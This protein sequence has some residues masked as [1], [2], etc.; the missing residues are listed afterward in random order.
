MVKFGPSGNDRLFYEDGNTKTEQA[1]SWLKALGLSAYEYSFGRGNFLSIETATRIGEEAK[2]NGIEVS[3]HAPYFINFANPLDEFA[4][5]GRNYL[6]NSLRNAKLMNGKRV[7][8]H[9]GSVLKQERSVALDLAKR[10]MSEFMQEFYDQGFD[11]YFICPETMGKFGQLGTV[12][13]ILELCKIDKAVIPTF[14]FGHINSLTQGSLDSK[15]AFRRV[16]EKGINEIGFEKMEKMHIHFSKIE[17][18]SKGEIRHLTFEDKIY[19]PSFEHLAPVLHEF[20]LQP[21]VICESSG[22][23]SKDALT[24]KRIYEDAA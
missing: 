17:Y 3:V 19:G 4:V 21:V 6:L 14:D 16:L 2:A 20:K 24:M 1:F 8:F 23:Q 18:G 13:E 11:G 22:T 5:N 9:V 10:R 15:D 12:D 7:V